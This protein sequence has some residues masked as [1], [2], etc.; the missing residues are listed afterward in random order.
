MNYLKK[1]EH[2]SISAHV[3][4]PLTSSDLVKSLYVF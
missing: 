4:K 2:S 3:N 1:F